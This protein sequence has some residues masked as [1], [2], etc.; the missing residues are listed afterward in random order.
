M[1]KIVDNYSFNA[2]SKVVTLNDY[3]AVTLARIMLITNVTANVVIYN[4]A[5]TALGGVATNNYVTL[6]YDTSGQASTDKLLIIY[7]DPKATNVTQPVCDRELVELVT[8]L[9]IESRVQN[10]LLLQSL[11]PPRNNI[12]IDLMRAE[13]S[14]I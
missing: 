2:A 4:F 5:N 10:S 3:G 6:T 7:D 12:N 9:L 8:A 14:N 13:N 11:F 1:K